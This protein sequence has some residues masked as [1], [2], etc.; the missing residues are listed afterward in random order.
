MRIV[1][2]RAILLSRLRFAEIFDHP[3]PDVFIFGIMFPK[4]HG[5]I[6]YIL[7]KQDYKKYNWHNNKIQMAWLTGLQVIW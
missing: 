4:S 5:L 2:T 6:Q 7:L 3:F 1:L